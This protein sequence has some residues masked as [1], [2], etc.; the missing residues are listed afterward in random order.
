[1]RKIRQMGKLLKGRHDVPHT[2]G[3]KYTGSKL[4][5]LPVILDTVRQ[6]DVKDV[7]DAFS[8]TT[9]VSQAFAQEGYDVTAND[10]SEWSEVFGNCY[11]ISGRPDA[12]YREIIDML[13]ALPG[14]DGWFTEHYG[15]DDPA[16][17][18]PFRIHNTRKLDAIRDRIDDLG[19]EWVDKCVILTSLILA[20]D[21]VDNTLGHFASYLSGWSQRSYR[22]LEMK[23]PRRFPLK[24]SNTVMKGSVFDAI[25]TRHDMVY[26]DPPYG[27]NNEKMPP[28]RV[29]YASYYHI[30]KTVILNDRPPLFGKAGRRDDTHDAGAASV[31]EEFR[32]DSSG[33]FIAMQ[34]IDRMIREADAEYILL[35]YS[36]G[37]RA[38]KRD[39]S[40]IITSYGT[41]ISAR[42]IDYRKNVMAGFTWTNEWLNNDSSHKEYLFL[43]RK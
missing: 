1:M 37:G 21:A 22:T 16:G 9:R 29:R 40:D 39:L 41:L 26:F 28:S 33:N 7:L 19:L 32:R 3:I 15:S 14:Y 24:T 8:G 11:L 38:T 6:L 36:S 12:Y 5:L 27:S 30:W 20:L 35:S 17:K 2:E 23:L 31:F 25:K 34:A 10:I 4:R 18:K 43:M 13:N 42:E